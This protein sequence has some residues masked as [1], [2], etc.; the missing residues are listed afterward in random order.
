MGKTLPEGCSFGFYLRALWRDFNFRK[1]DALWK[2]FPLPSGAFYHLFLII[3]QFAKKR[4]IA[5][6]KEEMAAHR[7]AGKPLTRA[8][9]CVNKNRAKARVK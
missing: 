3:Q 5:S 2:G 1:T 7:E 4:S 9:V 6:C 8:S